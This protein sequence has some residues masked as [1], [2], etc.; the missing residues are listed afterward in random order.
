MNRIG[1][2]IKLLLIAVIASATLVL[3]SP[4]GKAACNG[5]C[6]KVNGQGACIR[7]FNSTG[8]PI[9]IGTDCFFMGQSCLT[10][11]CA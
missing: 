4:S 2:R 6:G 9:D 10:T 11:Q 8:D 3:P 7:A 5:Q 1:L